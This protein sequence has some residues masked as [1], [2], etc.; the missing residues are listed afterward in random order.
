MPEIKF[1][2]T[3][4]LPSDIAYL[5]Y[6]AGD[7]VDLP[8]ASAR[9]W[10]RRGVAVLLP[11]KKEAMVVVPEDMEAKWL[12]SGEKF[13]ESLAASEAE[14]FDKLDTHTAA[15]VAPAVE[16]DEVVPASDEPAEPKRRGRKARSE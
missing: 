3:P 13:A 6:K 10:I 4:E 16:A 7:V 8:E 9:R 2:V 11:P 15:Q 5:A 1:T 12:E 14:F